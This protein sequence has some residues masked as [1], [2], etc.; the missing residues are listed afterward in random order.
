VSALEQ[1]LTPVSYSSSGVNNKPTLTISGANLQVNSG[2]GSTDGTVNGLGNVI[3]DYDENPGTQSGSNNL[4]LGNGQ[5]VTWFGGVVAGQG[6]SLSG[7]FS[8]AF[9]HNDTAAGGTRR[10][11][12]AQATRRLTTR[13]R[14]RRA[15]QPRGRSVLVGQRRLQRH[16]RSRASDHPQLWLERI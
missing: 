10:S 4:V 9:G 12:A 15:V 2:S 13:R 14:S 7:P 8:D 5:A 6:N 1:K 16:R 3:I 11:P